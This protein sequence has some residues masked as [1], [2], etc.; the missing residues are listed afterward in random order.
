MVTSPAG[1]DFGTE[2]RVRLPTS[3]AVTLI[4]FG[5]CLRLVVPVVVS[6]GREA[7]RADGE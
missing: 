6:A 4:F 1:A 5:V 7:D 2:R 3:V